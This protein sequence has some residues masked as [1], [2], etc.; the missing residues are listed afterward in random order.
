MVL[1][2]EFRQRGFGIKVFEGLVR[3]VYTLVLKIEGF[4]IKSLG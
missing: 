3:E 4:I 1:K 2:I